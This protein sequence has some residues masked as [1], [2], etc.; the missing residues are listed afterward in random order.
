MSSTLMDTALDDI[1]FLASSQHRF[2]VL[3]AL[4]EPPATGESS[5]AHRCVPTNNRPR[6]ER[7]SKSPLDHQRG[8]IVS[9]NRFEGVRRRQVG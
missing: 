1:E 2:S 7:H 4:K 6:S 5:D 3:D 8:T 9:N